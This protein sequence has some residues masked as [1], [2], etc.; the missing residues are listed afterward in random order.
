MKLSLPRLR[1]IQL[2]SK[3]WPLSKI[4]EQKHR[5]CLAVHPSKLLFDKQALNAWLATFQL[6][7][8]AP[9]SQQNSENTFFAFAQHIPPWEAHFSASYIF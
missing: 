4:V 1:Q 8:S 3:P 9:L 5:V 2:T 7:F 6:E